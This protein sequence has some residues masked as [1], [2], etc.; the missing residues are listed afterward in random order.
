MLS[1][2]QMEQAVG[3][4]R[5]LQRHCLFEVADLVL[6][7]KYEAFLVDL[8][9]VVTGHLI[10]KAGTADV[11]PER[12]NLIF[13]LEKAIGDELWMAVVVV[14]VIVAATDRTAHPGL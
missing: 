2:W 10:K 9:V 3:R 6:V 8:S 7:G 5:V 1:C 12:T 4:G 14:A 13:R 11:G